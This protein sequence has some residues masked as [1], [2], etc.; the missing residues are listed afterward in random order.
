M[1]HRFPRFG[2]DGIR[3][4]A[5]K[6][7]TPDV[8]QAVGRAAAELLGGNRV[9]IGRDTRRSGPMLEAGL[10]AG[11]TAAGVDVELLGVVPTP[12]VSWV[13][14]NSEI[15]GA[16]ISASHNPFAD[17]GI[18]LFGAGGLKLSDEVEASIQARFHEILQVPHQS[19]PTGDGIGVVV[20]SSGSVGWV[21][22]VVE[23]V[24]P[25]ALRKMHVVLDCANGSA[26][27]L[28][29]HVFDSLGADLTIIGADPNGVNINA[30]CGSTRPEYL[31]QAVLDSGADLG[32]AFD[33]DADRLVAVA[34]DGKIV[35]GDHILAILAEDWSANGRLRHNTIVVTVMSNLGFHL[36]M[37]RRGIAVVQTGVG[38]RYVLEALNEGSYSLGGEQS[39]HVICRDLA[40]TGDGILAGVQLADAIVRSG[41]SSAEC[42]A[43]AMTSVP[44]LLHNIRL[45]R[46]DPSLVGKLSQSIAAAE[47]SMGSDGRVLIRAS[48]TEPLLRVM[49]EHVD[50]VQARSI[51]A[52]LVA[53]AEKL[54]AA[55]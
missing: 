14:S 24:A 53:D 10:V 55:G 38:D 43:D 7:L 19:G 45:S 13:A 49:V 44:Q 47:A 42:A 34:S 11:Y 20:P 50:D 28:G 22:S 4:V 52:Q 31:Q 29:P 8:A 23:S 51:C 16:M 54:I 12:T 2:T 30:G 37:K 21:R 25:G 17:N 48:G 1:P 40:S 32:L 27:S 3:G 6:E 18:K 33:G 35:D 46:R 5:N 9:V 41:L 26:T 39:G 36:A 15:P